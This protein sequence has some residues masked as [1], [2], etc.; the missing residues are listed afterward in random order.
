M[1]LHPPPLVPGL[2]KGQALWYSKLIRIPTDWSEDVWLHIGACDSWSQVWVNHVAFEP[3]FGGNTEIRRKITS[4]LKRDHNG[5]QEALVHIKCTDISTL[6]KPAGKQLARASS[7]KGKGNL[8]TL[9]SNI[10]GIWQTVWLECVAAQHIFG[11]QV[12][13]KF[14]GQHWQLD[15]APK[16]AELARSPVKFEATLFAD[17]SLTTLLLQESMMLSTGC[18]KILTLSVPLEATKVW[19][20]DQPHLYGLRLTLMNEI[21]EMVDT[22]SS[23]TALRT[24]STFKDQIFV[25]GSATFLRLVLDQGY[26]P[27]GLWTAPNVET[28]RQ[29]IQLAKRLGFN[30]ARLHQKVFEP[31]YFSL[32]DEL[33][34]YTIAEYP[35]WNG[36]LSNRWE[37]SEAYQQ[38]VREEWSMLVPQLQN[39]PSIIGWGPF[40]EFGPKNGWERHHGPGGGFKSRYSAA[41]R[42]SKIQ[43]HTHFVQRTVDEIR[44][45][46]GQKRPIHDSSG[47]IHVCG[48]IWSFH[49]YEQKAERWQKLLEDPSKSLDGRKGQPLIVAEYGGVGFVAGGP[50]GLN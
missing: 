25:N 36:G 49:D 40:N 37:V 8:G 20:L 22:V 21:G 6:D 42:E 7:Y 3:H 18:D 15:I 26:F 34:F 46:D 24:V 4:A 16:V 5:Y 30:G 1:G 43:K 38:Y 41:E 35:D 11:V 13:P 33:G 19:N 29:D 32:A 47:W 45:L 48:D 12:V 9:Y 28:L 31:L 10:T 50:F 27:E 2:P 17:R 44:N 14:D 23:Y 39:H